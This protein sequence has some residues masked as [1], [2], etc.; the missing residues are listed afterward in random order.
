MC[1][2]M[3]YIPK[4]YYSIKICFSQ[5]QNIEVL[6]EWD[7]VKKVNVTWAFNWPVS[8]PSNLLYAWQ[9]KLVHLMKLSDIKNVLHM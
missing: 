8:S 4:F 7:I 3:K 1:L 5:N 6:F 2:T 9:L